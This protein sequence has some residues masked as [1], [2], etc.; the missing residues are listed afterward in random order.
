LPAHRSA[1]HAASAAT[2]VIARITNRNDMV[3]FTSRAR[4]IVPD[5]G[6]T[7]AQGPSYCHE[8][9]PGPNQLTLHQPPRAIHLT[10]YTAL[11]GPFVSHAC[12]ASISTGC[13]GGLRMARALGKAPCTVTAEAEEARMEPATSQEYPLQF[14]MAGAGQKPPC[15][16]LA[17]LG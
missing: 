13:A 8:Q 11:A 6:V 5:A 4:A 14:C 1:R 12:F 16:T 2:H 17:G 15:P 3:L 9:L 7:V 10:S